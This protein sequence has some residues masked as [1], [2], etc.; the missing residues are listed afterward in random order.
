M[1]KDSYDLII[2]GGG[3][4]GASLAIALADRGLRMALIEAHAPGADSQPSYDD[5]GIALAYRT[6]RIVDAIGVWSALE[7]MVEPILDIHVSD[8]GHFG[9]TG[10]SASEEGV[11]ALGYVA[12]ARVLGNTLI[13]ELEELPGVQLLAPARLHDFQVP[14]G[15][16]E[17]EREVDGRAVTHHTRLLV[18][19]DGAHSSVRE[20]LGI[21]TRQWDYGQTAVIANV[22]PEREHQN[23]AY[24]RF[25]DTGPMALLPMQGNH[26]ALVWTVR[27]QQAE[28]ILALSD[29]EFLA[30][31]Q[32]RFGNRLGRCHILL[33][34]QRR[35]RK[36][37]IK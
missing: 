2:V 37:A 15:K 8:R 31:L 35:F 16:V 24:E 34:Q 21:A 29:T 19:A 12:S 25:T 22:T 11:P 14:G 10:L 30:R 5:R 13:Q 26:C 23:V 7:M 36:R 18:A 3:M 4:V 17:A 28:E 27:S 6:R 32:Q 33:H 9:F 20:R 1:T